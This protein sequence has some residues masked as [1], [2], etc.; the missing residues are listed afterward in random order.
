MKNVRRHEHRRKGREKRVR[1][2]NNTEM[3]CTADHFSHIGLSDTTHR[4]RK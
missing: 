3:T 1:E 4:T 2:K